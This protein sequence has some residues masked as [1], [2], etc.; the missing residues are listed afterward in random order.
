VA[1]LKE[2]IKTK[3]TII[4]LYFLESN[5][6]VVKMFSKIKQDPNFQYEAILLLLYHKVYRVNKQVDISKAIVLHLQENIFYHKALE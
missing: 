5:E 2:L 1:T 4:K 6:E 3:A